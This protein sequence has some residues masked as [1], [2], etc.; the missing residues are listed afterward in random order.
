MIR[1]GKIVPS[2]T[3]FDSYFWSNAPSDS[4]KKP[5]R[6]IGRAFLYDP[7]KD[8]HKNSV[9]LSCH[10]IS[11]VLSSLLYPIIEVPFFKTTVKIVCYELVGKKLW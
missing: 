5:C 10:I 4:K 2:I 1:K 7:V 3:F 11:Q 6:R 9:K 8:D